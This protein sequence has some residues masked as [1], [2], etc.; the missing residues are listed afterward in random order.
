MKRGGSL[1]GAVHPKAGSLFHAVFHTIAAGEIEDVSVALHPNA[2]D[3]YKRK[4]A[5][6]ETALTDPE[7]C[8][9]AG[10]ALAA[11]IDKIILTPDP[12]A[13]DRL[14]INRYGE[15]A[16]ILQVAGMSG[17]PN[18]I[19]PRGPV[20]GPRRAVVGGVLSVVAGVGFEPTTFR[21]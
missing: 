6:L 18:D 9:Q 7:V 5:D 3:I 4:V 8:T 12:D 15:L 2:A 1:F 10:E 17:K 19:A 21:L 16:S 14:Q 11:L 20:L 13:P